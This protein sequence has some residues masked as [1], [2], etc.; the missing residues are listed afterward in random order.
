MEDVW[1]NAITKRSEK[2]TEIRRVIPAY[3]YSSEDLAHRT[4]E[5]V[6]EFLVT[7]LH[8]AK[9]TLFNITHTHFELHNDVLSNEFQEIRDSVDVFSDE[10]KCRHFDWDSCSTEKWLE[11]VIDHDYALILGLLKLTRE[12]E[13]T[14]HSMTGGNQDMQAHIDEIKKLVNE[15]VN[16]FKERDVIC[17]I[18]DI[19][20]ERTFQKIR[21]EIGS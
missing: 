13:D 9:D 15:L 16:S 6:C 2:V 1:N 12:L 11:R 4:D 8:E 14:V 7:G 17:N 20:L 18:K 5:K 3:D 19:T 21:T 10:I